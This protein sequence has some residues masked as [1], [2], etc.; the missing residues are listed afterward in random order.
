MTGTTALEGRYRVPDGSTVKVTL[1][2]ADM[3]GVCLRG[4]NLTNADLTQAD[5]REGQVAVP[6]PRKGLDSIRHEK[7]AGLADNAIF[8]CCEMELA[9][10]SSNVSSI[11]RFIA[12]DGDERREI[13]V[14][15]FGF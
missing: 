13:A 6:H 14:I 10:A 11:S 8:A 5:F 9:R 15:P 1:V 2:R 3:R 4:A 7:R 12:T